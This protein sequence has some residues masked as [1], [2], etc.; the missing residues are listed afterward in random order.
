MNMIHLTSF[1][2]MC[3][4]SGGFLFFLTGCSDS[5]I[6]LKSNEEAAHGHV[7][8]AHKP[9]SLTEAVLAI[10]QLQT[11]PDLLT[12]SQNHELED[13]LGWLPELAAQTDL[14]KKDWER[15]QHLSRSL[16]SDYAEAR[17]LQEPWIFSSS[18]DE[19]KTLAE[20]ASSEAA[21]SP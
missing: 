15:I 21:Y 10:E 11:Q 1:L 18:W 4:L 5:S 12:E 13:I 7:I 3:I 6:D 8:P 16:L 2:T 17:D 9:A 20:K 14:K 19:L